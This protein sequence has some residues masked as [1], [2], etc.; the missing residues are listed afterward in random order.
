MADYQTN[1]VPSRTRQGF[2]ELQITTKSGRLVGYVQRM[3]DVP[4]AI[5]AYERKS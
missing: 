5:A 2:S 4:A 1:W 3:K